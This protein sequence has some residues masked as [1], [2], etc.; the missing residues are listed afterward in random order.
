MAKSKKMRRVRN[1]DEAVV[2]APVQT[3]SQPVSS[4]SSK[5][6][7]IL[8]AGAVSVV[9]AGVAWWYTTQ[10]IP[11]LHDQSNFRPADQ[12]TADYLATKAR[13]EARLAE[14]AQSVQRRTSQGTPQTGTSTNRPFSSNNHL[15]NEWFTSHFSGVRPQADANINVNDRDTVEAVQRTLQ[16][17]G[18]RRD[19]DGDCAGAT[20]PAQCNVN[21]NGAVDES[22]RQA[23]VRFMT[24]QNPTIT[25]FTTEALNAH[26]SN[27]IHPDV[28]YAVLKYV[29]NRAGYFW[30]EGTD[31]ARTMAMLGKFYT[32]ITAP[33]RGLPS[34]NDSMLS[35]KLGEGAYTQTK[36]GADRAERRI[37]V[38]S[39]RKRL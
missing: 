6:P 5:A 9:L 27:P 39:R 24:A 19:G 28:F 23:L 38:S 33:A 15:L 4:T 7:V 2:S 30:T 34:G 37:V 36:C 12:R 32:P 22:T 25:G 13:E 16:G 26:T 8:I 35:P 1:P 29:G 10:Y 20:D 31:E 14:A 3:P 11:R 18:F 21:P 17:L